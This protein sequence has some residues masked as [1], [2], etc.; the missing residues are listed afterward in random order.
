MRRF[1]AFWFIFLLLF[2]STALAS[3]LTAI[4][5]QDSDYV[6]MEDAFVEPRY[7]YIGHMTVGLGIDENGVV[8][9]NGAARSWQRNIRI[10]L[11][12]QRST[13]GFI[14]DD[15]E[16]YVKRG[17]DGVSAGGNRTVEPGDYFYRAKLTTDVY[18]SNNNI[19]ETATAYSSEERY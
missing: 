16:S 5:N 13:N 17:F 14:W 1:F 15:L 8:G 10:T 2:T 7:T 4:E 6:Y 11:T 18:D 19:I 12:L 3:D 9:Y